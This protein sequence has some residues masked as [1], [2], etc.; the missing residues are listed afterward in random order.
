MS[1]SIPI[2]TP[3][4]PLVVSDATVVRLG[5]NRKGCCC[6]TECLL[7]YSIVNEKITMAA[8]LLASIF[9]LSDGLLMRGYTYFLGTQLLGSGVSLVLSVRAASTSN[10]IKRYYLGGIAAGVHVGLT[11]TFIVFELVLSYDYSEKCTLFKTIDERVFNFAF[12]Y[13]CDGVL[14][15]LAAIFA[16]LPLT[17]F[18]VLGSWANISKC[19]M[20]RNKG[21]MTFEPQEATSFTPLVEDPVAV[22]ENPNDRGDV[23]AGAVQER[24]RESFVDDLLSPQTIVSVTDVPRRHSRKVFSFA[25]GACSLVSASIAY[26]FFVNDFSEAEGSCPVVNLTFPAYNGS[27]G[28]TDI[29]PLI[30]RAK[31]ATGVEVDHC[32]W[33]RW[34]NQGTCVRYPFNYTYFGQSEMGEAVADRLLP[35]SGIFGG[36][37]ESFDNETGSCEEMLGLFSCATYSAKAGDFI[38][39]VKNGEIHLNVCPGWCSRLFRACSTSW[40]DGMDTAEQ[41][42]K[43]LNPSSAGPA[44]GPGTWATM[45]ED[46]SKPNNGCYSNAHYEVPSSHLWLLVVASLVANLA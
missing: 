12:A 25:L 33:R 41:C 23:M 38:T 22:V 7:V 14:L 3:A 42:C 40:C 1:E 11:L 28:G 5:S 29:T 27:I 39:V 31:P 45:K 46:T 13:N 32:G 37:S 6:T 17:I 2:A 26:S 44:T 30:F 35:G 8:L 24:P 15:K 43:S 9:F 19:C 18:R 21:S 10:P 36:G 4:T 20:Y 16:F 34:G